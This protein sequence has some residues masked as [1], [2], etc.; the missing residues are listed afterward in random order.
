MTKD[1]WVEVTEVH[2]R[3]SRNCVLLH[4]LH[5]AKAG[6]KAVT[7]T[8]EDTDVMV[9][10]LGF[11][12]DIPCSIYQKCGTKNRTRFI[13]FGK[14]ASSLG[15]SICDALIGLRA[16]TGCDT[17]GALTG[18]GKLD[19]ERSS[20][21][22]FHHAEIAS[23]CMFFVPITKH[24]SGRAAFRLRPFVADPK[25]CGRL[26]IEVDAHASSCRCC[27]GTVVRQVPAFLQTAKLHVPCQWTGV[28]QQVQAT[29]VQQ[30]EERRTVRS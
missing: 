11:N 16:F 30:S 9:L 18:R 29:D 23:T 19:E 15:D 14:L 5:A 13:D 28:H 12:R 8:A 1:D 4:A 17:V 25:K 20:P 7:V 26:V 27:F 10:C 21:A 22:S 6:S 2:T 24:Q 3:T